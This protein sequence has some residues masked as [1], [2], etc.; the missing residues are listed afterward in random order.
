MDSVDHNAATAETDPAPVVDTTADVA[1]VWVLC[2]KRANG[3]FES[4]RSFDDEARARAD[5]ELVQSVSSDE[6][7]LAAVPLVQAPQAAGEALSPVQALALSWLADGAEAEGS[8]ELDDTVQIR[9]AHVRGF[10]S[11]PPEE[12]RR[13][14]EKGWVRNGLLTPE[15]AARIGRTRA[16]S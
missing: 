12:W 7:W 11:V 2:R 5:L 1:R 6:F 16:A 10:L 3:D 8:A 15:G 13:M 4:L 14:A 9:P